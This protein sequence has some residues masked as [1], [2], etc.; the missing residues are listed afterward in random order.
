MVVALHCWAVFAL[1][2]T[3]I[4]SSAT[5]Q[6]VL[7]FEGCQVAADAVAASGRLGYNTLIVHED[8]QG[9]AHKPD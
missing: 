2:S 9:D 8:W 6:A 1:R 3:A 4:A 7:C 5:A